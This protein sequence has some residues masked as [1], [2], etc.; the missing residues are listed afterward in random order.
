[1][2]FFVLGMQRLAYECFTVEQLGKSRPSEAKAGANMAGHAARLKP[3]PSRTELASGPR[4]DRRSL[5]Q[6]SQFAKDLKAFVNFLSRQRLQAL[7]AELLD[8]E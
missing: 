7:R 4:S 2:F 1:V 5:L 3:C 8:R 6:M